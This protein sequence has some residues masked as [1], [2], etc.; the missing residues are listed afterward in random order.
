M[1]VELGKKKTAMKFRGPE[2]QEFLVE[3]HDK[4]P[5]MQD[6]HIEGR[7]Y[8]EVSVEM[9]MYLMDLAGFQPV[10]PVEDDGDEKRA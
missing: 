3:V 1:S 7:R 9:F 5:Q 8:V 4:F 2:D 6:V 10:I